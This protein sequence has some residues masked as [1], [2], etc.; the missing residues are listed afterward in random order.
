MPSYVLSFSDSTS[1]PVFADGEPFVV[2]ITHSR[3]IFRPIP[4]N[5]RPSVLLPQQISLPHPSRLLHRM[6]QPRTTMPPS[7]PCKRNF[8]TRSLSSSNTSKK[9][10]VSN[11]MSTS[12]KP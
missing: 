10:A 5:F 7:T 8:R 1:F 4:L 2:V 9:Y 12:R 6:S 11:L 3:K